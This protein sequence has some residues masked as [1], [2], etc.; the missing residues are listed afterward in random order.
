VSEGAADSPAAWG[1]VAADGTVYVR[2]ADGERPVG[3]WQAGGA[4]EALAFYARRYDD[5]AAEVGLLETRLVTGKANAAQTREAAEKLWWSL[6]DANVVGD[7]AALQGRL[8]ALDRA[9]AQRCA[10]RRAGGAQDRA[11]RGGRAARRQHPLEADRRPA[12]GDRD[13]LA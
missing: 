8:V 11:R 9:C 5:L 3:S 7:I 2:T 13:D 10:R 1:R 6:S 12:A 4:D